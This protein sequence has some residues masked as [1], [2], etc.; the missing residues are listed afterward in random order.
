[1]RIVVV[2][3]W[4]EWG[5]QIERLHK[6]FEYLKIRMHNDTMEAANDARVCV[7]T[8]AVISFLRVSRGAL[9][10]WYIT[11]WHNFC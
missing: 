4:E 5:P 8:T 11:A 1:M 2:Q 7:R 6:E 10:E 9:H 3:E